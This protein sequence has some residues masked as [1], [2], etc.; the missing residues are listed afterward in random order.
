[1]NAAV[2]FPGWAGVLV[3]I[4]FLAAVFGG[5]LLVG[6]WLVRRG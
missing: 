6:R 3:Y 1:M 4:G 5:T 2:E